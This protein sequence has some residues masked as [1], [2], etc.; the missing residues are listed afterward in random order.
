VELNVSYTHFASGCTVTV[1]SQCVCAADETECGTGTHLCSDTSSD[2]WNCGGCTESGGA[3]CGAGIACING[4]CGCPGAEVACSGVCADL[5]HDALNCGSCGWACGPSASCVEGVC[6][7]CEAGQASVG[8]ACVSDLAIR[9]ATNQ[10]SDGDQVSLSI[11]SVSPG[12][13]LVTIVA[14]K[15]PG[16]CATT[17]SSPSG[18]WSLAGRGADSGQALVAYTKVATEHDSRSFVAVAMTGCTGLNATL[19]DVYSQTGATV[20][21][22][23]SAFGGSIR[24][25]GAPAGLASG[26]APE[27]LTSGPNELVLVAAAQPG[28]TPATVPE[29]VAVLTQNGGFV[30][31][32]YTSRQ[33]RAVPAQQFTGDPDATWGLAQIALASSATGA[34][35]AVPCPG[36]QVRW[37][38]ICVEACRENQT[39]CGA[40]C[41]DLSSDR[42]NCGVCGNTC[43][44]TLSCSSGSCQPN[45]SAIAVCRNQCTTPACEAQCPAI[46]YPQAVTDY[47]ALMSCLGPPCYAS[48]ICDKSSPTYVA[49]DC[50]NCR[51][52][53]EFNGGAC[54]TVFTTCASD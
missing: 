49:S 4:V 51:F 26:L 38:G 9:S 24:Q 35:D 1:G 2:P 32:S 25:T 45:C 36:T 31:G 52:G 18:A 8:G 11:G 22:D 5:T 50:G 12:D 13:L 6:L 19:I 33:P 10:T 7:P 29:G 43:G 21:V 17:V 16:F 47:A 44:S 48:G 15:G 39:R 20:S 14:P 42:T 27:L 46:G 53:L 3:V 37:E 54:E 34:G 41:V 30:T 23:E 28:T 40:L